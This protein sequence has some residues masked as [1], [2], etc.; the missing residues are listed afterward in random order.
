MRRSR[1]ALKKHVAA[2]GRVLTAAAAA[3]AAL[4]AAGSEARLRAARGAH[5]G[6]ALSPQA[7]FFEMHA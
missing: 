7:R 1:P 3:T 6:L 2:A 5:E 4:A